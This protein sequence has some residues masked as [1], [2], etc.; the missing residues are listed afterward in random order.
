MI[1]RLLCGILLALA[2][3][4]AQAESEPFVLRWAADA[5]SGAPFSFYDPRD[6]NKLKGFEVEI[7]DG[8]CAELGCQARFVQNSWDGLIPGLA[9]KEYDIAIN[10]IEITEDRK[11]RVYFA[12]T[13]YL[14]Y[15]QIIVRAGTPGINTLQDLHGKRVGT[16]SGSVAD[17]IL[18]AEKTIRVLGYESEYNAHQD[19]LSGRSDALLFDAPIAKY[20]SEPDKRF[21][22]L[23]AVIGQMSYGIAIS[24]DNPQLLADV[25]RALAA[26]KQNGKLREILERWG[27]WNSAMAAALNATVAP[28]KAAVEFDAY[29]AA[30]QT[31]KTWA[32]RVSLYKKITPLLLEAA[33]TTMKISAVAMLIAVFMGMLLAISRVLGPWPVKAVA[34][35]YIEVIRGTPLLL[36]LFLIFYA[37]PSLGIKLSPFT[38][39]VLGLGLN[40]G[41]YEAENYRSGIL[42]V[43]GGQTDA[44]RALGMGTWQTF[45][46]VIFPQSWKT[47]LPPM[48][49]DFISLLKDSSIV[50]VITMVELTKTY[51][52]LA[53]VY[54]DHIGIGL[55]AAAIYLLMGLPFVRL[56]RHWEKKL[57]RRLN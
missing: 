50:S 25:N 17:R 26:M 33:V 15:N 42:S 44:A 30:T 5:E 18:R 9:R 20:Y 36:Q 22:I 3:Y 6:P 57:R 34:V 8:I 13:Y 37:L 28:K 1:T 2:P 49:N 23:P 40:Y 52:Q 7:V 39:A 10:G 46:H 43:P 12:D 21:H 48:T 32:D 31:D 35:I 41:A 14:T 11:K 29:V 19:L 27:L 54:Y 38:A 45:W 16:L 51:S 24:K 47:I 56:A 53:S 55:I 4:I